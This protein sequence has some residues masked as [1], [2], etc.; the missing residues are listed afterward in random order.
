MGFY[1]LKRM[2]GAHI[3]VDLIL[4][5]G[6]KKNVCLTRSIKI[7]CTYTIYI[8][9]GYA[10]IICFQDSILDDP[11][12]IV[13]RTNLKIDT[14]RSKCAQRIQVRLSKQVEIKLIQHFSA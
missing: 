2:F 13:T 3:Y 10:L 14:F 8:P 11:G 5:Q 1:T 7:S 12:R 9:C 4:I 6:V